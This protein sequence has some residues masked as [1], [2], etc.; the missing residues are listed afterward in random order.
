MRHAP[1]TL[2]ATLLIA[3]LLGCEYED[4]VELTLNEPPIVAG[5]LTEVAA[6]GTEISFAWTAADADGHI[7]HFRVAIVSD[8]RVRS[9]VSRG[10]VSAIT[11]WTSVSTPRW[12]TSVLETPDDRV[13]VVQ[14]I[15]D[16]GALSLPAIAAVRGDLDT[17][18]A[19]IIRP[20]GS[21]VEK[22]AYVPGS[23]RLEWE[24]LAASDGVPIAG[25]Q[26]KLI[27][28]ENPLVLPEDLL[29]DYFLH[30][31]PPT[32]WS[33]V[34]RK[35][36]LI[37]EGFAVEEPGSATE[38][39]PPTPSSDH[40]Y[41]TDWWPHASDPYRDTRIELGPYDEERVLAFAV[42]AV[43]EKGRVTGPEQYAVVGEVEDGN[44]VKLQVLPEAPP[45]P[46]LTVRLGDRSLLMP[47]WGAVQEIEWPGAVPLEIRW[48]V[49]AS[50]YGYDPG[51]VRF[52][53]DCAECPS[54][55]GVNEWSPWG[56]VDEL[57]VDLPEA[58][59]GSQLTFRIEARDERDSG[60][61]QTNGTITIDVLAFALDR[62]ALVIDDFK[63][64]GVDDCEHD[65]FLLDVVGHAVA[66]YLEPDETLELFDARF[67]IP[68]ECF[69]TSTPREPDLAF[70]SRYRA[71]FWAVSPA[72]SGTMLG[73]ATDPNR[74]AE[75][76]HV[77]PLYVRGGGHLVVWGRQTVGALLGD[78]YPDGPWTPD[79]AQF[80]EPNY[81]PGSFPWDE[82]RLR[83][84]LDR[85]GR[86]T[87]PALSE[88]CSGVIGLEATSLARSLGLPA[89]ELDPTGYDP[90][91]EAIW[92]DGWSGYHHLRGNLAVSPTGAPPLAGP[93]IEPLYTLVPNAWAWADDPTIPCGTA[94]GSPF[95]GQP[96]VVRFRSPNA[97]GQIIWIG[98]ELHPFAEDGADDV[99]SL[100]R[101]LARLIY[102]G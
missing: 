40:Y 29:L 89:G 67:G 41:E 68:D 102:E 100:M 18:G 27:E 11:T 82:M 88:R 9:A 21:G 59:E 96:V 58:A 63:T 75:F 38:R 26:L 51:P 35:N 42:R 48:D 65:E 15:D 61:H 34:R 45:A 2:T 86:G 46:I 3:A 1:P 12:T 83:V 6:S 22:V 76:G 43:D 30:S 31:L 4:T 49:D 36:L 94:F 80:D 57:A 25:Y 8:R 19:R 50:W 37:P 24:G 69:E 60:A 81:G 73:Y 77:L 62:T 70:L 71:L 92:I 66:P 16:D 13:L 95:D 54:G 28:I 56:K 64:A 52:R 90:E 79:L 55:V 74:I 101:G 53:L 23:L 87:D 93:L 7:D 99:R 98:V 44:V 78:F 39:F 84:Q 5:F 47:P 33:P 91:R 97:R 20:R 10:D 17:P 85:V 14:A 72:G 32:G